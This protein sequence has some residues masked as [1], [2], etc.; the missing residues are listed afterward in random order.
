[1]ATTKIIPNVLELNPGN[2]VNVLKATN[3]VTVSNASGANKYYFDGV[4]DGKFGLRIGTTVLTGVP[5]AHPIAILNDG[6]TGI[7]Y[8]GT[9]NEGTRNVPDPGGPVYTFYSGDVTITVTADFGGASYYCKIHGYMGGLDNLVSVYSDAGLKMPSG[10]A[11]PGGETAFEGMMRNDTSQSSASSAS[12]MQHYNGINWK[13]FVNVVPTTTVNYLVVAGGG[14]GGGSNSGYTAGAGGG[15]GGLRTSFGSSS[16][17]GGSVESAITVTADG[18]TTYTVTVG[19]GGTAG[20]A[21]ANGANGDDS[22]FSSITSVGGGGGGSAWPSSTSTLTTG[23]SGGGAQYYNG[24][25]PG[26][27]T[28][29][30]G[31]AGGARSSTS[32]AGS[33]SGGGGG[34]GNGE[35]GSAGTNSSGG[36]GGNGLAVSI[37]GSSVTYAGGGGGGQ[38][39]YTYGGTV[40]PGSGGTGG[41]GDAGTSVGSAYNGNNGTDN[42]GGGG[43]GGSANYTTSGDVTGGTGGSGIVILR[44]SPSYNISVGAGLVTGVENG[45]V[46]GGTDKYTTFTSGSGTITFN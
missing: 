14:G 31:N 32:S 28:A 29:N 40:S 39:L 20:T 44:Y 7:T 18:T 34:A 45:T 38:W 8:T 16:G 42:L 22:V 6:L 26:S 5:S 12:T 11:F 36:N 2:P 10:T 33:G 3:A 15:A 24:Q 4:Y 43:G 13:N 25:T 30:Q 19:D 21:T 27:G 23:G 41:G 46:S 37:T 9:V 35:T 1:M 17:G